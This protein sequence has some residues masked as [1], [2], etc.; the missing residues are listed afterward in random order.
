MRQDPHL[1]PQDSTALPVFHA[2]LAP[3]DDA[4]V[5]R[6]ALS[7]FDT[8]PSI[9]EGNATENQVVL[10]ARSLLVVW[11]GFSPFRC[12]LWTAF[13]SEV[14]SDFPDPTPSARILHPWICHRAAPAPKHDHF[15]ILLL[16][17]YPR[18]LALSSC[19]M[20][21]NITDDWARYID[22]N[23]NALAQ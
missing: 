22:T 20:P 23:R 10:N 4:A 15:G 2:T 5:F 9:L 12:F 13:G 3:G 19:T 14:I 18:Q 21:A 1:I 8:S 6:D 7:N 11:M 16:Q 17:F